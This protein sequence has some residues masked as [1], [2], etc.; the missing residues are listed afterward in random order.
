MSSVFFST[1]ALPELTNVDVRAATDV[2][3]HHL[4]AFL[5]THREL[6]QFGAG[7]W[8]APSEQQLATATPAASVRADEMYQMPHLKALE[9]SIPSAVAVVL[10]HVAAPNL[11]RLL[12]RTETKDLAFAGDCDLAKF[13]QRS[14][15]LRR[16]KILPFVDK[17]DEVDGDALAINLVVHCK[18]LQEVEFANICWN[19]KFVAQLASTGHATLRTVDLGSGY[20]TLTTRQMALR[21][22]QRCP[23][24]RSITFPPLSTPSWMDDTPLPLKK[25]DDED[26]LS[27]EV[28]A[29][30]IGIELKIRTLTSVGTVTVITAKRV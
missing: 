9:I 27:M 30:G 8:D 18:Q 6:R 2:Q 24:L 22:M 15:L 16:V 4:R 25:M 5:Q 20:S 19:G 29:E 1:R 21:I 12:L 3:A 10:Q 23:E 17:E 28:T 13:F 14:P 26:L 7:R 11:G